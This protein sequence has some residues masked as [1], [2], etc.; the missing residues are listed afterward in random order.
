MEKQMMSD[1]SRDLQCVGRLE[2]V[3]P[4]PVGFLCG[5]LPVPTDNAFHAFNSALVPSPHTYETIFYIFLL[6]G[7]YCFV[8]LLL[9]VAEIVLGFVIRRR[10]MISVSELQ[11]DENDH[12]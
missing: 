12:I 9:L 1:G 5:T 3:R 11:T 8:I 4:K 2:I 10:T 6:I 7:V